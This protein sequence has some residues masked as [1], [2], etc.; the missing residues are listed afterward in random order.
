MLTGPKSTYNVIG[1]M[2]GTSLDGL[3][4]AHCTFTLNATWQY[5]INVA[6][7]VPYTT[8][9]TQTL[10]E[11]HKLSAEALQR[12]DS[13]LGHYFAHEVN[14]FL[15]QS[16]L[17]VDFISSHGHTIFH[18]PTPAQQG[19]AFT[20]QIG[21]GAIIG[22]ITGHTVIS[23]FRT[24][25]VALGGQG[26]PLVP[27]GD[28]HLFANYDMCINIG[29]IVNFSMMKAIPPIA[30]DVCFANMAL[31]YLAQKNQQTYDAFGQM[32]A[33][34]IFN[35]NLFDQLQ[36]LPFWQTPFP[37]SFGKEYFEKFV[38]PIIESDNLSVNDRLHTF[39]KHI[40]AQVS[41][42]I[43]WLP[44]NH[45]ILVTGG[46]AH[47]LFLMQCFR[48][49]GLSVVLPNSEII[50]F[51]EALIFAFLGVLRMRHEYNTLSSVTGAI[52]NSSAGAIY[53]G[54]I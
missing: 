2:S 8:E 36:A 28:M 30:S 34:G 16:K 49:Q 7:T 46:G 32:A 50:A 6:V 3:D 15:Q 11:A 45:Q 23:D 4:I 44:T 39:C 21:S 13:K 29:G 37:K 20:T 47:N 1:L 53:L 42:L 9:L 19:T 43:K 51:K 48:N 24:A 40:A 27:I 17:P 38:L 22:A 41:T 5:K 25:D 10:K 54:K 12:L 18:Q 26:A 52:R 35:Q 33:D 14:L 31:N